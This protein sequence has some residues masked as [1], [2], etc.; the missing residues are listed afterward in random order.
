MFKKFVV[1]NETEIN[2]SPERIWDFLYHIED[3]YSDWHPDEHIYF[4]WTKGK[5][6][7]VGSKL[8]SEEKLDGETHEIKAECIESIPNQKIT[9]KP[10]WPLSFMCT[11]IIW[12]TKKV[13]GKTVFHARTHF[14]FGR[15]FLAFKSAKAKHILHHSENHMVEEGRNMK[16]ILENELVVRVDK[17]EM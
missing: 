16:K 17:T 4:R 13:D 1:E 12:M 8:E 14:R 10:D 15:L 9:L 11:R 2:T 6:L 7:E 3:N 5:P